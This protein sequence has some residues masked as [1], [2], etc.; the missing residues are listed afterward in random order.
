MNILSVSSEV[1]PFSR[2]GGMGD[3]CGALPRALA[4]RGNRVV[5]V[6]PRYGREH[7]HLA[8][9]TGV[10]FTFWLF[11]SWHE[12]RY[13]LHEAEPGLAHILVEN[14][15]FE[16]PG[17]Y[18]DDSGAY[19]DNLMRFALLCRAA[20]EVPRRVPVF[21]ALLGDDITVHA[22]D[23]HA[24][25]ALVY[26]SA[27]YKPLGIYSGARGVLNVHN[28]AHHGRYAASEY[29]GL[30]L[31]PR[32][33]SALADDGNLSCLKAGIVCASDVVAVSPTFAQE[34]T[35]PA[36][37]FGMDAYLRARA[38]AGRLHGVLNGVDIDEWNP[39]TDPHLPAHFSL[40]DL[41]G[42]AECK[43]ALQRE[44]GLP[45][46]AD[47][48]LVGMVARLDYQKGVDLLAG[49]GDWIAR[50]DMQLVV[51]GTGSAKLAGALQHMQAHLPDK[52]R[53]CIAFDTALS[54][55]IFAASDLT[56]V[57]SRFEP[58]GLT[59]MYG[60]RYGAVPVVRS[61]GGL[62]D[63][64]DIWNPADGT[65]VGWRFSEASTRGLLD[66]L[67]WALLTWW[68]HPEAFARIRANGM[69]RDFS[70]SNAAARYEQIYQG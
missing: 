1:A 15:H 11:G 45:V 23:W 55:R 2:T 53:A 46:R 19:G 31:S 22:H 38:N 39:E 63:T 3:V 56:L 12:V 14:P 29:G 21:G 25:L 52:V 7:D 66:A 67:G 43:A 18:G 65:G 61:T 32:H 35:T 49:V 13:T 5:T 27:L 33:L 41:S 51:L 64:V 50:Q 36:G 20:L 58:C 42:K 8:W 70:W 59:Q 57:P 68:K 9:D 44:L 4:A 54:H 10:T 28:A 17:I 48:P 30:D 26:L 69:S 40:A 60:M 6:S 34:L 16:R 37:G 24:S 47:V 62:V